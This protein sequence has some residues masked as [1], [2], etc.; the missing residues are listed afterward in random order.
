[1]LSKENTIKSI[2]DWFT[3]AK[4]EPTK[5]DIASQFAFFIEEVAE[6]FDATNDIDVAEYLRSVKQDY[7]N[8]AKSNYLEEVLNSWNKIELLDGLCDTAV[9]VNGVATYL[10]MNFTGALEHISQSNWSKFNENGKPILNKDGKITKG[11]NYFKPNLEPF[12]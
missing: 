9:T 4:P 3:T 1:M 6:V 10:G 12:V 7:L 11:P 2:S 5:A 8:L